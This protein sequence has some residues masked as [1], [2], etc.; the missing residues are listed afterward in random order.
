M[1]EDKQQPGSLRIAWRKLSALKGGNKSNSTRFYFVDDDKLDHDVAIG[2]NWKLPEPQMLEKQEETEICTASDEEDERD[3]GED[4]YDDDEVDEDDDEEDEADSDSV[5]AEVKSC[6]TFC[7]ADN[8]I[9]LTGTRVDSGNAIELKL[10]GKLSD[11]TIICIASKRSRM[12]SVLGVVYQDCRDGTPKKTPR[13]NGR[14]DSPN[15]GSRKATSA[16]SELSK[17]QHSINLKSRKRRPLQ[18]SVST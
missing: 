5:L 11:D 18:N 8:A 10:E 9:A 1:K 2:K 12:S 15:H 16:R 13:I 7:H 17:E 3:D 4:D 6:S 14:T